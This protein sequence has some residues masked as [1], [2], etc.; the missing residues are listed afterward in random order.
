MV[1]LQWLDDTHD[2]LRVSLVFPDTSTNSREHEEKTL[3]RSRGDF[4]CNDSG[5]AVSFTQGSDIIMAG[6]VDRIHQTYWL[7]RGGSLVRYEK[8]QGLHH[9]AVLPYPEFIE[10][11][12]LWRREKKAERR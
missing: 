7:T 11:Y 8:V 12:M 10:D 4:T 3:H 1:D 5:L 2:T 9:T 6:G